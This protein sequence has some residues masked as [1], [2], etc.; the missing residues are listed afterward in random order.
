MA[1]QRCDA[2]VALGGNLGDVLAT[3]H[4]VLEHLHRDPALGVKVREVAPAYRTVALLPPGSTESA[5]D[6]WN[7]VMGVSTALTPHGLLRCLLGVERLFGRVRGRRRW[8]SR[9]LDLDL[10]LYGGT[11]VHDAELTV[12]HPRM[13]QRVFVLRPLNDIAPDVLLPDGTSPRQLLAQHAD[14][15]DGILECRPGWHR[16]TWLAA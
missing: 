4:A 5:P 8:A 7:S 15:N 6:Y 12:P 14:S 1:E 10:L 2:Y 9:T 3:F 16:T 11:Q 13:A